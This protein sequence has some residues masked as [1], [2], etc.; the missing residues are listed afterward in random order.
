MRQ[1]PPTHLAHSPSS[2]LPGSLAEELPH[3]QHAQT[4]WNISLG[5]P[6]PTC[7]R[8]GVSFP[9]P[10]APLPADRSS[11]PLDAVSCPTEH[12]KRKRI[13]LSVPPRESADTA[14][15]LRPLHMV[16]TVHLCSRANPG[17]RSLPSIC[18]D[19]GCS[20]FR[21]ILLQLIITLMLFQQE[22]SPKWLLPRLATLFPNAAWPG[23]RK[24]TL[25]L[26]LSAS[27]GPHPH[28]KSL[29]SSSLKRKG[30]GAEATSP[31]CHLNP[32]RGRW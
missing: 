25:S 24:C 10:T 29:S 28:P 15:I 4:R 22:V 7:S 13:H 14:S 3:Q 12:S 31:L 32:C 27:H 1:W 16:H 9:L 11:H 23:G 21:W 8:R 26:D 2:F 5:C 17:L 6:S 19:A 30:T 18:R 20:L